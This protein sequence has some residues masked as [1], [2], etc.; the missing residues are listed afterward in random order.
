MSSE[1]GPYAP[2]RFR[3]CGLADFRNLLGTV[4]KWT[5]EAVASFR[6]M[7]TDLLLGASMKLKG[8]VSILGRNEGKLLTFLVATLVVLITPSFAADNEQTPSQSEQSYQ[9]LIRSTAGPNL[10]RAYC[11]SCHGPDAKGDGP[12]AGAL[13]VKPPDLTML[14]ENNGGQFP[15]THIRTVIMGGDVIAS[16]GSREMPIWGPLFHQIEADV[17]KG[18]VRLENLTR[19]LESI[20]SI[21]PPAN[22]L[23]ESRVTAPGT[24]G[25]E[26]YEQSCAACHGNDLKGNGPAPP[27][28]RTPPDLTKLA[29]RNGGKFP[30]AYVAKVLRNGVKIPGHGPAEMPIW[31]TTFRE[32]EQLNESQI[33]SRIAALVNYIKSFQGN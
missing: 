12:A 30:D 20:Q 13:K 5:L 23:R 4:A 1:G 15:T 29:R 14:A 17:D 10:F 19:Y 3:F 33:T 6:R 26:L 21:F 9:R 28:F 31:G 25:A 8:L 2:H 24:S 27:L 11:A 22:G 18:N 16:H 7:S 32:S